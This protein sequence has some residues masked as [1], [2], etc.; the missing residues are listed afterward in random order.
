MTKA[1]KP[2]TYHGLNVKMYRD[3]KLTLPE[4]AVF[5]WFTRFVFSNGMK[6]IKKDRFT[7]FWVCHKTCAFQMDHTTIKTERRVRELFK[8][9]V[10]KYVL[11]F[12]QA[13]DSKTHYA[14]TDVG[15]ELIG[16]RASARLKEYKN[17]NSNFCAHSAGQK[18][19]KPDAEMPATIL[20]RIMPQF[21]P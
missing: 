17:S 19:T 16:P 11:Y 10:K 14:L 12:M 9:L 6:W 13:K 5:Y 21:K 20:K 7:F 4:E 18:F 3:L 2:T 15:L 8:S 1:T